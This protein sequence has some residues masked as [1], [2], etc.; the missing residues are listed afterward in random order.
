MRRVIKI[1]I[2][3]DFFNRRGRRVRRV[4]TVIIHHGV[5]TAEGAVSAE[6]ARSLFTMGF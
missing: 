3:H 1:I 4:G 5:F 2:H 6:W